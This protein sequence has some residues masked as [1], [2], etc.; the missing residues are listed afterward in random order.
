M[1]LQQLIMSLALV[2]R[3]AAN[4]VTEPTA[5]TVKVVIYNVVPSTNVTE[6]GEVVWPG[7][8][9]LTW[10][11]NGFGESGYIVS[12]KSVVSSQPYHSASEMVGC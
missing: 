10:S 7:K 4:S 12:G 2:I 3:R 1:R 5:V 9:L 11:G 8:L 6:I